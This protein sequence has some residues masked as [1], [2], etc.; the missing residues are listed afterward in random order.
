MLRT[1]HDFL[2]YTAQLYQSQ[3]YR[4]GILVKTFAEGQTLLQQG[5]K[6][7]RVM[8]LQSGIT[9]CFF[10]EANDKEFIVEFLGKGEII[11]EIEAIKNMPCLCNIKALTPVTVYAIAMPVFQTLLEKDTAF[12]RLLLETF[13]NRIINTS[14]R[15]S[16]QQSYTIEHTLSKLLELQ[17]KQAMEISKEDMAAYLGITLRSLNRALKQLKW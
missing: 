7:P 1:N 2:L 15:A 11:G 8:L 16:F 6:A 5:E 4:E 10:N 12:N 3:Q 9:K 13:A 14:T 17:E